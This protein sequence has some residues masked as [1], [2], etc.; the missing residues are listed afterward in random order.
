MN[1]SIRTLVYEVTH[2]RVNDLR[3]E[4]ASNMMRTLQSKMGVF[5]VEVVNVKVTDV[6][7]PTV[8]SKRLQDTTAFKTRIQAR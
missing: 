6:Q 8:L 5:G 2:D 1:E 3:S 4:F 7:L